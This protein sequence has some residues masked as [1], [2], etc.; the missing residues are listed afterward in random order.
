M[1]LTIRDIEK[2]LFSGKIDSIELP[3]SMGSFE[4]LINHAPLVS[5]LTKGTLCYCNSSGIHKLSI[6]SGIVEVLANR[7]KILISE[8]HD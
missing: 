6:K 3:G 1:Y 8:L 2:E 4:V 7:I 5:T